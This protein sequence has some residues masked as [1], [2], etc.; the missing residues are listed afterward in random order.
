MLLNVIGLLNISI[1]AEEYTVNEH[2]KL[3]SREYFEKQNISMPASI[4]FYKTFIVS[5]C[6][7]GKDITMAPVETRAYLPTYLL[8]AIKLDL[9]ELEI[10]N[11]SW[12]SGDSYGTL[13]EFIKISSTSAVNAA[14]VSASWIDAFKIEKIVHKIDEARL[15]SIVTLFRRITDLYTSED[16]SLFDV[17]LHWL[18]AFTKFQECC[19]SPDSRS[20]IFYI[21]SALEFLL[22]NTSNES[23]YRAALFASL[24]Y[25]DEIK[26]RLTCYDFMKWAFSVRNKLTSADT[27]GEKLFVDKSELPENIAMLREILAKVLLKTLG[28]SPIEL[29]EKL[30]NMIF[31]CP[32]FI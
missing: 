11:S 2:V 3:V 17:N 18:F 5:T 31:S 19:V 4:R 29:Q 20:A 14:A 23:D 13:T 6:D 15:N 8:G 12:F 30:N 7:F 21:T 22:V 26:D 32:T 10:E 25:S 16:Q 9:Y 27:P 1:E 24:I 28:L